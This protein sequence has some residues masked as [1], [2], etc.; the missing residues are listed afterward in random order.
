MAD[1]PGF[2]GYAGW[3]QAEAEADFRATGGV[4]K[5]PPNGTG[6]EQTSTGGGNY[7]QFSFDW[8]AAENEA[9]EKLKPYYAQK[10][11]EAKGD[12]NLAKQRIKSLVIFSYPAIFSV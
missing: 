6:G 10:L 4:G 2:P 1:I 11:A 5:G 12:V 8:A 3:E 7:P 9:L